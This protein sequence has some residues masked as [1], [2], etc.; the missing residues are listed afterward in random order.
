VIAAVLIG[1][2]AGGLVYAWLGPVQ[3]Q[4]ELLGHVR[5]QA[6]P[7]NVPHL[8]PQHW[9]FLEQVIPSA[10]AIAVLGLAQSLVIARD[11]KTNV[12]RDV[13]LHKEVFAQGIANTLSP[14]FSTF[15]GSGSFNRTN[16]AI[17]MGA[18]TPLS[19]L[20][21]A[22]GVVALAWA[23]GPLLSMLP[24]PVIGGVLAL[25]GI[26]MIQGNVASALRN[27]IEG[28]VYLLSLFSVIFLGLEVGI[29]V[30]ILVS[31]GFFVA[32]ASEL[33]LTI[34]R[35]GGE[36]RIIVAGNLYYASI[37]HLA[38]HLH[39][40]PRIYSILDI[41]RVPYCDATARNM[42]E[43]IQKD[44]ARH[45]GRLDVISASTSA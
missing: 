36:E 33:K 6:L 10:I 42:I 4:L 8:G 1:S 25:V 23:V 7:L 18:R 22:I 24:M 13:D 32:S 27:R 12:V 19:G 43:N 26:G 3:S 30:A 15:A 11:I 45:G 9:L 38:R 14:F 39:G 34:R 20:I 35:E 16:V 37:D 5:L 44:R 29:F 31:I 2:L 28:A 17:E 21:A 40:A 41:S